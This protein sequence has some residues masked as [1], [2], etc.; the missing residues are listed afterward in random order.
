M[1]IQFDLSEEEND[2]LETVKYMNKFKN[3]RE[4][5]KLLIK[6]YGEQLK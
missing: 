2:V 5:I 1:K 3:K 4:S 6:L